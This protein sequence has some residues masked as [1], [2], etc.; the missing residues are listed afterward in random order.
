MTVSEFVRER[1]EALLSKPDGW[2]SPASVEDQVLTMVELRHVLL[3]QPDEV[4]WET[5]QRFVRHV[6]MNVAPGP[7][8]LSHKLGLHE[9]VVGGED[10]GYCWPRAADNPRFVEVLRSFVEAE[11]ILDDAFV[12]RDA[13]TS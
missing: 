13:G 6:G 5:C 12:F 7:Q 10:G 2:G 11:A 8:A 9:K 1:I 4:V 3:G